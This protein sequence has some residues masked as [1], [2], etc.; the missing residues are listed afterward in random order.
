MP[1]DRGGPAGLKG[2][3]RA[4][5]EEVHSRRNPLARGPN[6]LLA[7]GPENRRYVTDENL[8][9]F[10]IDQPHRSHTSLRPLGEDGRLNTLGRLPDSLV[11]HQD[12]CELV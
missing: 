10:T 5:Q 8:V 4:H 12:K 6:K 9:T 2:P 11:E 7:G 1:R 3:A